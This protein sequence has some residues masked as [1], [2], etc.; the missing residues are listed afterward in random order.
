MASPTQWTWI[1][2]N[3]GS[4]W[5]TGRPGE[6]QSSGVTE[7][8]TTERLNWT[9]E[10]LV[11]LLCGL[12]VYTFPQ[13]SIELLVFSHGFNR[14]FS[15]VGYISHCLWLKLQIFFWMLLFTLLVFFPWIYFLFENNRIYHYLLSGLFSL[16][17]CLGWIPHVKI[18]KDYTLVSSNTSVVLLFTLQ[19]LTT[20]EFIL[21]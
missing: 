1:W 12:S 4:W 10:P 5:W 2:L 16:F 6:L 11:F 3:S 14:R 15:F 18:I 7:S 21:V 9:E 19:S 17:L 13:V 20:T 8:D